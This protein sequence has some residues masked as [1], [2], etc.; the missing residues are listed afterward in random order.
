MDK[1]G[2]FG[3]K[4]V[5][6]LN[7][8]SLQQ[9]SALISIHAK[10]KRSNFSTDSGKIACFAFLKGRS[11]KFR[12]FKRGKYQPNSKKDELLLFGLFKR[13]KF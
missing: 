9:I 8:I 12:L 5:N 13:P 7:G 2:H 3:K 1:K 10:P 11:C 4:W 6:G